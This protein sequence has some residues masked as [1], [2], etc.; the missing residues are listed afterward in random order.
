MGVDKMNND[1]P[2]DQLAQ[3]SSRSVAAD[4]MYAF[5]AE[6]EGIVQRLEQ[7]IK[8]RRGNPPAPPH[9]PAVSPMPVEF[10]SEVV[11]ARHS[12]RLLGTLLVLRGYVTPAELQQALAKQRDL[13]LP[14]G[15]TLVELGFLE[16]QALTD[17][18]AEQLRIETIDLGRT[19]IDPATMNLLSQ[20]DARRLC[21][22]P[23][24]RT[25]DGIDV[26]IGDP[27]KYDAV[28]ELVRNLSAPV[29]LFL[30]APIDI[31]ATIDRVYADERRDA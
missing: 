26:A 2:A 30:A 5:H 15:R 3:S 29:R 19:T 10:P 1:A 6:A 22:L 28:G 31:V 23:I 27:T 24:R 11:G 12:G 13:G 8:E 20:E 16:E 4:P 7:L 17:A 18:L 9:E 14:L 25:T 21:A